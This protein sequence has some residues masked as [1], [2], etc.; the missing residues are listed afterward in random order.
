[1]GIGSLSCKVAS[2]YV[3]WKAKKVKDMVIPPELENV[4]FK[5]ESLE[6]PS[7]LEIAKQIFKEEK[8]KIRIE[9][10]RQQEKA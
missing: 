6:V 8:K 9:S 10:R 7:E 1:M 3:V 2:E 5:E 4:Q